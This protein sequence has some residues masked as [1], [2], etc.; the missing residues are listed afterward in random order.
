MKSDYYLGFIHFSIGA[1]HPINK[2]HERKNFMKSRKRDIG[3]LLYLDKD[4][5]DLLNAKVKESHMPSRSDF[6]RHMIVYGMVYSVDYSDMQHYNW[7]LSNMTNNLNQIAHRVNSEGSAYEKDIKEAKK[8]VEEIWKL[9]Q[10][11]LSKQ[12]YINL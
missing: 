7:L 11:M 10:S 5:Y 1:L 2:K 12:P 4:E 8:I 9:Q 3:I 6:L